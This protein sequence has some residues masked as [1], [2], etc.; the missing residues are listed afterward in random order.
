MALALALLTTFEPARLESYAV[1]PVPWGTIA[2]GVV[3]FD[4]AVEADGVVGDVRVL[5]DVPPFTDLIRRKLPEWHFQPALEDG[6]PV[7]NRVLV[8]GV[9]RPA[10]LLFPAPSQ[11]ILPTPDP[12]STIPFPTG[13]AIAPYPPNAIGDGEVMVEVSLDAEG[14]VQGAR[15]VG[16]TAAFQEA[17]LDAARKWTFRPASRKGKSVPARAYLYFSFRQPVVGPSP[18]PGKKGR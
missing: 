8:V 15:M 5:Q 13:L 4:V 12:D 16:G 9:F 1:D 6:N 11:P 2:A 7:D 3:I 10:M 17:A 18:P 14:K